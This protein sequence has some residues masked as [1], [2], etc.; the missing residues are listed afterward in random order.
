[1]IS[2]GTC[3]AHRPIIGG[4]LLLL[5]AGFSAV[6]PSDGGADPRV[7]AD[8][9]AIGVGGQLAEFTTDA[10]VGSESGF[11]TLIRAE[12]ELG[13][14]DDQS[15]V[16]LDGRFRI[17]ERQAIGFG[18]WTLN[19]D[20]A[21]RIDEQIEFDGNVFD[22]GAALDS[23]M[24]TGWARV[25]WRYSLLKTDRGEAGLCAGLSVYRFDIAIA[26]LATV[27]DGMGGTVLQAVRAEDDVLAPVPT[28]GIF[29]NHT[30][31]RNLILRVRADLIDL[32]VGDYEGKLTDTSFLLEWYFSRHVGVGVG[33]NRFEI[34]VRSTGDDP[35]LVDFSQSGLMGYLAFAF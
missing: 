19:R 4:V 29:L 23:Q 6:E 15:V 7:I 27:D 17:S 13:L 33:A 31:R 22:I 8:R 25:D 24:D 3:S 35:F 34:D 28:F 20:G 26:G 14:D 30:L 18:F 1:M 21:A 32:D 16:R 2:N 12:S 5:A 10:S 9:W 11:G